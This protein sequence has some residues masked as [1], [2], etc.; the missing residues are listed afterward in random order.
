[1]PT[2]IDVEYYTMSATS[3]AIGVTYHGVGPR[4]SDGYTVLSIQRPG[5]SKKQNIEV[6]DVVAII[7][8][9]TRHEINITPDRWQ[10][11]AVELARLI[12]GIPIPDWAVPYFD[13]D[14]EKFHKKRPQR[15][16]QELPPSTGRP[17][18][19][20]ISAEDIV[21]A[22]REAKK[23]KEGERLAAEKEKHAPKYV[24][25]YIII[26]VFVMIIIAFSRA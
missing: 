10:L 16:R 2:I 21:K 19:I 7:I 17:R 25:V 3:K 24:M 20:T 4:K 8:G 6:G 23:A 1:M 15:D 26:L 5:S 18:E 22:V 11:R 9:G 12:E 14:N 13:P